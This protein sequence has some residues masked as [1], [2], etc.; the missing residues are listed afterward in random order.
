MNQYRAYIALVAFCAVF[1]VHIDAQQTIGSFPQMDGGFEVQPAGDLAFLSPVVSSTVWTYHYSNGTGGGGTR[2][3]STTNGRSGPKFIS[4]ENTT[5]GTNSRRI[6]SPTVPNQAIGNAQPYI[7]QFYYRTASVTAVNNAMVGVSPEGSVSLP[8]SSASYSAVSTPATSGVWTKITQ[9][10]TTSTSALDPRYGMAVF[11]FSPASGGIIDIDDFVV[12]AGSTVDNTPPSVAGTTSISGTTFT[13]MTL[14]WGASAAID[15]GGYLVMRYTTDPTGQ[16]HPNTNGI[17]NIGNTIGTGTVAYIGTG[18]S[19]V[20]EGL[21][22]STTYYYRIYAVDKAFNYASPVETNG[23]TAISNNTSK[24]YYIDAVGGN[25]TNEGKSESTAWRTLANVNLRTFTPGDIILFKAGCTWTGERLMFSGSGSAANP[26]I[27]DKYSTG[28]KPILAG[29]GLIGQGV[30]YLH[31]QS[32]IEINNLEITNEPTGS[33]YFDN[34]G[35]GDRRGIMV[36]IDNYGTANHLYFKN[37]DIHNIKGQLGSGETAVNGA[38]PKRTGGIFFNVVG[39]TEQTSSNSRFNDVLIDACTISYCE[40]I[41]IAVDNEWNVYYPGGQNSSIPTDVTEYNNWFARRNT[42]FKISNNSIHHIGKN[43]LILRMAD[44]SCLVERNICYETA[45][46]TTGN[47]MFTARCKGTVFQYNEGYYNRGTT[48]TVNPGTIDGSLYDADFGSVGIIFQYSYSHDNSEGLFWGCNTRGSAN[49]TSKIPD[50]GDVG[51]TVRYNISQ[52]DRGDLIFFNY[53]S[54]GNEI[55][56]NVFYIGAG[57]S[58]NIIHENS[59]Q[60]T[61]NFFNN[62]IY[63]L[64]TTA[65]YAFKAT[66]QTRTISNNV[67]YGNHPSVDPLTAEPADPFK[68]T[69]DPLFVNAG[70]GATC[71]NSLSGYKLRGSS[72]ALNAGKVISNN[73]GF[74]YWGNALYNGL[75]D[76][77]AFESQSIIPVTLTAFYGFRKGATNQ[78]VWKT[79]SETHN[80]GFDIE[81]SANGTDFIKWQTVASKS[82]GGNSNTPMEYTIE[83]NTSLPRESIRIGITTYYRLKQIGFDDKYSYSPIVAIQNSEKS[84]GASIYPNPTKDRV[85]YIQT[86]EQVDTATFVSIYDVRGQLV[87]NLFINDSKII[88]PP[89]VSAGLYFLKLINPKTQGI[90]QAKFMVE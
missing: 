68:I 19:L 74:D 76:I 69:A 60:H 84:K 18:T 65:D 29:N 24:T 72:P 9:T 83:D 22:P 13:S 80:A 20:N 50:P 16:P 77:G 44:E 79:S 54:T 62:I 78:L 87:F 6:N 61:Y 21:S 41:G 7:V 71:I 34:S 3:V 90:M 39:A 52:N 33:T 82:K 37:L 57:L 53:P 64:S 43:A 23:T 38:I 17:Y 40:N 27:I 59:S 12:Y 1:T 75:P 4:F 88:L 49:N 36:S 2:A 31:N 56:N 35:G 55:Y 8:S 66:E 81:R 15:G 63:N 48:Q 10:C 73:G 89:S 47:T 70:T 14:N 51:C 25:D 32:Y 46:G 58:P 45:L 30:V 28:A 11:R 26:I 67:F 5:T 42:N 85:I 86:D